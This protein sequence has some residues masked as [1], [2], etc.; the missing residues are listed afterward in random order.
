MFKQIYCDEILK[1]NWKIKNHPLK[2]PGCLSLKSEMGPKF[3][4]IKYLRLITAKSYITICFVVFAIH[5]CISRLPG[6]Y[7][8][9]E[10]TT[11]GE[12]FSF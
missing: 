11:V 5:A 12:M 1:L 10:M 3:D 4:I 7:F 2:S 6:F 8:Q 9:A